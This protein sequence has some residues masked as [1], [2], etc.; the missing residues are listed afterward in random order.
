M[1]YLRSVNKPEETHTIQEFI[2]CASK[3]DYLGYADLSYMEKRDNI[4]YVIKNAV[5]DYYIELEELAKEIQ[6][7]DWAVI[8]YRFNPKKLSID[9]YN[10]TRLWHMILRIN[11][12]GNVHDF[13]L[14]N[15]KIKLLEPKDMTN[16]MS[17]VYNAERFSLLAYNGAHENDVTPKSVNKYYP[18]EDFS[19]RFLYM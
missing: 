11:G 19:Q 9:L 17:K 4:E 13:D 8:K 12:M 6:F 7:A 2:Q 3:S 5:D 14:E 18:L 10:T 15:H 1:I 16:F